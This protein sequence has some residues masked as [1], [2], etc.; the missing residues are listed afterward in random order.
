MNTFIDLEDL[1]DIKDYAERLEEVGFYL[2]SKGVDQETL[3]I[4]ASNL[5]NI[6]TSLQGYP[7]AKLITDILQELTILTNAH[8]ET[9]VTL[10][11]DIALLFDGFVFDFNRWLNTLFFVGGEP[12]DFLDATFQSNLATIKQFI[13][14]QDESNDVDDIAVDDFFDF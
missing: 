7:K 3:S 8:S 12:F 9:I 2:K 13:L 11:D 1:T 6:T 4:Y 5:S 14:P 10:G